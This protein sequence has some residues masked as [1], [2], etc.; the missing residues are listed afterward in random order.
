MGGAGKGAE[1]RSLLAIQ[2]AHASGPIDLVGRFCHPLQER[3]AQP[4]KFPNQPPIPY[5]ASERTKFRRLSTISC[6]GSRTSM[7]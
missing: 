2:Q 7:V 5:L 6:S 3:T 4:D 1:L